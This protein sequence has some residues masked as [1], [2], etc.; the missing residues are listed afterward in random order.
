MYIEPAEKG[1]IITKSVKRGENILDY[2]NG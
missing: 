2:N 1:I